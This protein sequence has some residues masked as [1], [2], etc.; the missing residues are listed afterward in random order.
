MQWKQVTHGHVMA[1]LYSQLIISHILLVII[2]HMHLHILPLP[3]ISATIFQYVPYVFILRLMLVYMPF[4]H[5]HCISGWIHFAYGI[6]SAYPFA[7]HVTS[8]SQQLTI[9]PSLQYI[10]MLLLHSLEH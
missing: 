6:L 5:Y 1:I 9:L 10:E 3:D 7:Q 4:N 2:I 8:W